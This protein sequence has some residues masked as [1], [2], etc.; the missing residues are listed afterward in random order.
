MVFKKSK[1]YTYN[2]VYFDKYK[3]AKIDLENVAF[4]CS[5]LYKMA[6]SYMYEEL[7]GNLLLMLL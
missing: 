5:W 3:Y 2:M 4:F 1:T 6:K 7:D